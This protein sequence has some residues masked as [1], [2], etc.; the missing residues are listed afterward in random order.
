MNKEDT[1]AGEPI[2]APTELDLETVRPSEDWDPDRLAMELKKKMGAKGREMMEYRVIDGHVLIKVKIRKEVEDGVKETRGNLFLILMDAK[3]Q[4][5]F[6]G[7]DTLPVGDGTLETVFPCLHTKER[8]DHFSE[9]I[10][11]SI[12]QIASVKRG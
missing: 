12:R 2:N 5:K 10:G 7:D 11:N 3:G 1:I 6:F 8:F 4:E 9:E